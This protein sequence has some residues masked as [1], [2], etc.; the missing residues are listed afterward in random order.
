M[1]WDS[2]PHANLLMQQGESLAFVQQ[3]LEHS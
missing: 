2:L 1:S 3:Q